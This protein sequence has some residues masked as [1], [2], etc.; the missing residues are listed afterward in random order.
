MTSEVTSEEKLLNLIRKKKQSGNSKENL[1]SQQGISSKQGQLGKK[2]R[3]PLKTISLIFFFLSFACWG[4][5]AIQYRTSEY[6]KDVPAERYKES[7]QIQKITKKVSLP[8]S[9]PFEFYEQKFEKRDLFE[10]PGMKVKS[11]AT[12]PGN[13]G[14]DLSKSIKIIGIVID[15]DS[16]AIVEDVKT[17]KTV[18]MSEGESIGS[19]VIDKIQDDKVIFN[20]NNKE[21]ELNP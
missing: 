18:F 20:Y 1:N 6:Q 17:G 21:V 3:H 11:E 19:A 9:R 16:K 15:Q 12:I 4:Y 13:M 8:V 5:V 7:P 14:A 10:L 2:P